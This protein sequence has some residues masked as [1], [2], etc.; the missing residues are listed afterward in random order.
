MGSNRISKEVAVPPVISFQWKALSR[1]D[2]K[3]DDQ[4]YMLYIAQK[5]LS[6]GFIHV[7]FFSRFLSLLS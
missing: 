4:L 6:G 5:S 1:K 2:F 3:L 7:G